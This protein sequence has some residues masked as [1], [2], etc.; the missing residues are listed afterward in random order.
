MFTWNISPNYFSSIQRCVARILLLELSSTNFN[1]FEVTQSAALY[2][3][4]LFPTLLRS[5]GYSTLL[6]GIHFATLWCRVNFRKVNI[7]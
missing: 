2:C 1:L 4:E 3:T 6:N 5:F 7:W